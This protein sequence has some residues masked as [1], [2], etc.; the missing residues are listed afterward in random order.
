VVTIKPG[1]VDT[2]LIAEVAT[3]RALTA[4]PGAVARRI[5]DAATHGP[6]VIYTP[7]YWGLILTLVKLLPAAVMKRLAG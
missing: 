4:A 6:E 5:A 7:R 1:F 3:P 2:P